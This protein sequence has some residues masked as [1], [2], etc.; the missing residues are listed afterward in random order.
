MRLYRI[1]K[2]EQVAQQM[3][4][5]VQDPELDLDSVGVYVA[6]LPRLAY[7]RIIT[8]IDSAE[9]EAIKQENQRLGRD[10]RGY[11]FQ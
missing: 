9:Q 1:N 8:V 10:N 3:S 2:Q 5:L 7:N 6:R 4:K 11:L